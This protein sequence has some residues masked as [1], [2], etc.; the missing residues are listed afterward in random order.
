MEALRKLRLW[1]KLVAGRESARLYPFAEIVGYLEVHGH[2]PLRNAWDEG[3]IPLYARPFKTRESRHYLALLSAILLISDSRYPRT[4]LSTYSVS[5]PRVGVAFLGTGAPSTLM[6]SF[7]LLEVEPFDWPAT[8]VYS[9]KRSAGK[10]NERWGD[11][12]RMTDRPDGHDECG[13][14]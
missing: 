4:S 7:G 13:L 8:R 12:L 1:R 11:R 2:A 5:P 10:I 9:R 14:H 6:R 3:A